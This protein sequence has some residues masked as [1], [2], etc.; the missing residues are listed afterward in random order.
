MAPQ[1]WL[2]FILL[3]ILH[4]SSLWTIT[5]FEDSLELVYIR[6]H[7]SIVRFCVLWFLI[8]FTQS[9]FLFSN[10]TLYSA[11]KTPYWFNGI[12]FVYKSQVFIIFDFPLFFCNFTL[13]FDQALYRFNV[14]ITMT[15]RMNW[16]IVITF[17]TSKNS[18][19]FIINIIFI[20][21]RL[22]AWCV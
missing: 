12:A 10:Q 17:S 2:K 20:Q 18:Y 16:R 8:I 21:Y 9:F 11:R 5:V 6:H 3:F 15:I 4:C 13:L 19:L 22:I 14:K 1:W 7:H